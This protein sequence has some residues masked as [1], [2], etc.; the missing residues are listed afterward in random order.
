[1]HDADRSIGSWRLRALG[2]LAIGTLALGLRLHAVPR[3]PID[4][5]EPWCLTAAQQLA[6]LVR[7][8][9]LARLTESNPTPEH[10]QLAKVV[11]AGAIAWV[12]ASPPS[13][14]RGAVYYPHPKLP[15]SQLLAART[16]SAVL[17]ALEALLLAWLHPLAGLL[18][19]IH[20]YTVKFTSQAQIEALPS[21]TSLAAV[22]S[23]ARFRKT[24]ASRWWIASAALL[25]LTAGGKYVY[26]VAGLAIL[27]DGCLA[28]RPG[29]PGRLAPARSLLLWGAGSL[30][31][32][33]AAT[34]YFWPD[35]LARLE[36]SVLYLAAFQAGSEVREASFP[37][38]QPLAWLTLYMPY[39]AGAERPYLI[40]IDPLITALACVGFAR[41]WRRDRV[42]ALWLA[43]ALAFLLLW[44]TKW[45]HYVPILSAPLCLCAAR[46]VEM[47]WAVPLRILRARRAAA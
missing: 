21:L 30:L 27:A 34:P 4:Y 31:V 25:G 36:G 35:P 12:P 11:L 2:A 47:L 20:T 33:F 44:K 15:E 6:P 28:L 16:A 5:E 23:W 7:A 9:E 37:F 14:Q 38:W 10:P 46:G 32:F 13:P 40:R 45:P 18:L 22:A 41:A 39:D 24:G 29:A 42:Y 8:G 1:V 17:G 43:I 26:A 3:L 19:A